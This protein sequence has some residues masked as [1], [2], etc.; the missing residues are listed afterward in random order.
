MWLLFQGGDKI[1]V[2]LLLP[3]SL[4]YVLPPLGQSV[5]VCDLTLN[6]CSFFIS[7]SWGFTSIICWE[8]SLTHPVSIYLFIF[9]HQDVVAAH[10]VFL[11]HGMPFGAGTPEL[12]GSLVVGA[13]AS[14]PTACGILVLWPWFEL[15]SPTL[16]GGFFN[17]FG[18]LEKSC[19]NFS[20]FFFCSMT[21]IIIPKL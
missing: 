2:S 8:F 6:F 20:K 1:H 18:P 19:I 5:S 7:V 10:K 12:M 4:H 15:T 14:C 21:E 17:H 16:E 9:S 11:W 3:A 13:Q